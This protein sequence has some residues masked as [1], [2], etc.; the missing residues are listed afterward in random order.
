MDYY[1]REVAACVAQG[2]S[3]YWKIRFAIL[4]LNCLLL[5]GISHQHNILRIESDFFCIT[6]F[7]R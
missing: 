4:A 7:K 3:H 5:H 6:R 1:V 2:F